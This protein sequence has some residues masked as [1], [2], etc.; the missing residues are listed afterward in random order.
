MGDAE[1]EAVAGSLAHHPGEGVRAV[2]AGAV[3]DGSVTD[4][5][6]AGGCPSAAQRVTGSYRAVAGFVNRRA[7]ARATRAVP[8]TLHFVGSA[9]LRGEV[10]EALPAPH[11]SSGSPPRW[12]WTRRS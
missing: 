5:T 6:G 3:L 7:L 2:L 11:L 1:P 8:R 9:L 10:A 4:G 12:P